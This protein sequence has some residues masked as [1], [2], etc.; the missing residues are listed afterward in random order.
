MKKK[1][2]IFDLEE[3]KK[4]LISTLTLRRKH[5]IPEILKSGEEP[6]GYSIYSEVN[7]TYG[8]KDTKA[9]MGVYI[10]RFGLLGTYA[11][12]SRFTQ[13]EWEQYLLY[14]MELREKEKMELMQETGVEAP[15]D[16]NIICEKGL[17][18]GFLGN[19]KLV[20]MIAKVAAD[21]S[22]ESIYQVHIVNAPW[23]FAKL[24]NMVKG[25]V[26]AD[27]RTK[28]NIYNNVPTEF[29]RKHLD[30]SKLPKEYGGDADVEV[31]T[32]LDARK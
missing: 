7:P 3:A 29:F 30:T 10:K 20:K 21:N 8:Y 11:K 2:R 17:G 28:I 22:P 4:A 12:M 25:F 16:F 26:D 5:K 15:G 19:L 31:G 24:Y 14:E 1:D 27:T 9:K 23:I 18:M 32:P 6:T 13:D